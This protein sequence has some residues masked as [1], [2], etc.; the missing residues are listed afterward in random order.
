MWSLRHANRRRLYDPIF[1]LESIKKGSPFSPTTFV[2]SPASTLTATS[3]LKSLE[4]SPSSSLSLSLIVKMTQQLFVG[5]F[6][7]S[8]KF[9]SH[10]INWF[11]IEDIRRELAKHNEK[12]SKLEEDV[13]LLWFKFAVGELRFGLVASLAKLGLDITDLPARK[14]KMIEVFLQIIFDELSIMAN[15]TKSANRY[16]WS[17]F[18]RRE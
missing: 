5:T 16:M 13:S 12:G 1:F 11:S 14:S 2:G 15:L 17:N 6:H 8:T 18:S 10:L 3:S 7:K 9:A 4:G